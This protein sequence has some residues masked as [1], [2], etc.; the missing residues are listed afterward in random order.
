M[1]WRN[2]RSKLK[3]SS[4]FYSQV[5]FIPYQAQGPWRTL[6]KFSRVQVHQRVMAARAES[7]L[8]SAPLTLSKT[9]NS[10]SA[11][12]CKH[13]RARTCSLYMLGL[14]L[15]LQHKQYITSFSPQGH[16]EVRQVGICSIF[17]TFPG[18]RCTAPKDI[19]W[20]QVTCFGQYNDFRLYPHTQAVFQ[21]AHLGIDNSVPV[22]IW[23]SEEVV[24]TSGMYLNYCLVLSSHGRACHGLGSTRSS[25]CRERQPVSQAEG[26]C[27]EC[28][29][30][31]AKI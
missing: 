16:R 12:H 23:G 3:N 24:N 20:L 29:D 30:P 28:S 1:C 27:K 22:K 13:F 8:L 14:N 21:E 4:M 19:L 10:D 5:A 15:L 7:H 25:F 26:R 11:S 31:S 18:K 9:S 17:Q 6:R 2:L